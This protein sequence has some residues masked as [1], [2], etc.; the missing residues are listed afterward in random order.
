MRKVKLVAGFLAVLFTGCAANSVINHSYNFRNLKSIGVLEFSTKTT[1]I[2][3]VEDMFAQYLMK[4]DF[5]V[6]ERERLEQAVKDNDLEQDGYL[7][8]DG[9]RQLGRLLGVNA[10]LTGEVS[11]F[12]SERKT[13][14]VVETQNVYVEPVYVTKYKQNANGERVETIVREGTSVHKETTRTPGVYTTLPR[15]GIIAKLLDVETGELLW[16]GSISR[17]DDDPM[18]AMENAVDDLTDQLHHDIKKVMK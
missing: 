11:Y 12:P 14:A 7:D 3:G 13:Q 17:E 15:V 4:Y 8:P 16:V 6:V 18:S 9:I 2:G 5:D 1:Q 10:V